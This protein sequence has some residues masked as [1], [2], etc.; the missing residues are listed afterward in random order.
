MIPAYENIAHIDFESFY[1]T[2]TKYSLSKMP[3]INYVRDPRY[4]TLGVA[5][6]WNDGPNVYMTH[7]EFADWA[8]SVDWSTTAV[9]AYNCAFDGSVLTQHYGI[10]PAYYIDP[11]SAAR[12][13]LAI[14]RVP[15]KVVAPLLGLGEK[16]DA[17]VS[18]SRENTQELIDYA[19]NDNDLARG[20]YSILYPLLTKAEQDLIH[21]TIRGWVEPTLELDVA[22]LTQVRDDA[23]RE[24]AEMIKASGYSDLALT[25]NQQ[26]ADIIRDLGLIPPTKLSATTGEE[27]DAFSKGDDEFVE[28]MLKYPEHKSLWDARLAAKSNINA[29][30]AEKFLSIAELAP[31]TPMPL[32]YCGAH[33]GRWSGG[34]GLNVQNLPNLRK[35]NMR[36]AFKAPKDHVVVVVDSAQIELRVNM[37]FCGQDDKVEILR[38]DGDLYRIEAAAQYKIEPDAVTKMQR[39]FGKVTQLA[40]LAA[41]TRVIT[42]K[43]GCAPSHTPIELVTLEHKLWDG[44]SWVQHQGLLERGE[45]DTLLVDGVRLTP[46]HKVSCGTNLWVDAE[47]LALDQ[48]TLRRA[49]ATGLEN[50]RSLGMSL[51]REEDYP[52]FLSDAL[53]A[54]TNTGFSHTTLQLGNLLGATRALKNNPDTGLRSILGMLTLCRTAATD[55]DSSLEYPQLSTGALTLTTQGTTTTAAEASPFFPSGLPTG[56][57]FWR[58]SSPWM[59]GIARSLSLTAKIITSG[60]RRA[61]FD[62]YRKK[63]IFGTAELSASS[64]LRLPTYDIALAGTNNRF[65]ILSDSGAFCVHNCGYGMGGPK[66]RKYCAAAPLGMDPIYLSANDAYESVMTYRRANPMVPAMWATLDKHIHAMTLT[67]LNSELGCIKFVHEGIELPSGRMLQYPNLVQG[68]DGSWV[69]GR[70]KKIKFL[71]GGTLL[72]NIIQAMAR[73]VVAEQMLKVEERYRVVSSTHDEIIYIAHKSDADEALQFGLDVMSTPPVWAPNLPVS[74]EGGWDIMY[75]K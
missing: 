27:T 60:T 23:V 11:M 73:D 71:W 62:L 65:T 34:D 31:T 4:Q 45:K 14:D 26:F 30:R 28:F 69:Y 38:N 64:K 72:E 44:E 9:S 36:L 53:A 10:F 63:R 16:G 24:R 55:A 25:S 40:C 12:A 58:T 47:N 57:G 39:Q 75:S 20:V 33:T 52:T 29:T 35:S 59:G 6:A 15:L 42:K 22:V 50:L 7:D 48:N 1:C 21:L 56:A 54:Q 5:V 13:L 2:K 18:G 66:F 49:L 68:D 70:D 51:G 32:N 19:L 46:D 3:T 41:G 67:D 17:L 8:E 74:A 37:W 61:I 43:D